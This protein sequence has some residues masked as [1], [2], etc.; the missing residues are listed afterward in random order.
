MRTVIFI[1]FFSCTYH[2]LAG[3]DSQLKSAD[4][5]F[6]I[7]NEAYNNNEYDKAVF[8]YERALLLDP[9][10]EDIQVNLQLTKEKLSADIVDAEAFFLAKWWRGFRN[11][12]MPGTWKMLSIL[13]LFSFCGL[14]YFFLFRKLS[15]SRKGTLALLGGLAFLFL[16]SMIAGHSRSN[17]IYDNNYAVIMGGDQSL[18]LGPDKVSE[19][20]K[21]V[22]GGVKVEILESSGE[23]YKVSAMDREQGW[24]IKSN[25][26]KIAFD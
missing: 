9:S 7:G 10:A 13:F 2:V 5:Y 4:E 16:L 17:H 1:I 18:Y 21:D 26:Q 3:Q 12:F 14:L 11:I 25:V 24:I 8:N 23:W 22:T 20:I 19:E 15:L 6:N